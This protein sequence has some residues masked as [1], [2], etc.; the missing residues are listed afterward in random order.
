MLQSECDEGSWYDGPQK[1]AEIDVSDG[2]TT[3]KVGAP[4]NLVISTTLL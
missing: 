1:M 3:F 2:C 4:K